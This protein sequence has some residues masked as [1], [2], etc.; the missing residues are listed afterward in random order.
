MP[1]IAE[2]N[3]MLNAR[4]RTWPVALLAG[5]AIALSA[6]ARNQGDYVKSDTTVSNVHLQQTKERCVA[7]STAFGFTTAGSGGVARPALPGSLD[8]RRTVARREADLYRLCMNER[9]FGKV[10]AAGSVEQ[11]AE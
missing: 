4:D 9:G 11:E 8:T 1:V 10:T 2:V 6:C 7:E 3:G 5:V